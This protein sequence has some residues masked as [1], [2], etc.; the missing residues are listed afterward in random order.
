VDGLFEISLAGGDYSSCHAGFGEPHGR[1]FGAVEVGAGPDD[2]VGQGLRHWVLTKVP[3]A[4]HGV[5]VELG[6][7]NDDPA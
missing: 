4:I 5:E 2:L 6:R 3:V 7:V 1:A